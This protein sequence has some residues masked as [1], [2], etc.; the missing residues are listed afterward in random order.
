MPK[1]RKHKN[2][3]QD[4]MHTIDIQE[5]IDY[6]K[7]PMY[8]FFKYKSN[9]KT[10]Y[11]STVEK[12]DKDMHR[13]IYFSFSRLQEGMPIRIE[14]VKA[15]WGRAWIKDKR[16]SDIIF[17]DTL[18]NKDTY[19][20]RRKKGINSLLNFQK[21]FSTNP[22]FPVIINKRYEINITKNLK[23]TGNFELVRE[24][25]DEF[26]K[27][28]IE[29]AVF[30]TDEHTNNKIN[31]ENDLNLIASSIAIE[32]YIENTKFKY[33]LYHIDKH[34]FFYLDNIE[35]HKNIFKQSVINIY[36]AIFNNIFYICPNE[37]C[38]SCTY[39]ELCSKVENIN[40]IVDKE[41]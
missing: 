21:N 37:R 28:Y 38:I 14:D 29:I 1:E 33:M 15:A 25:R 24:M 34:N 3:L 6:A 2:L 10:E 11:I 41:V 27:T 32:E 17:S 20:E 35:M 40:K 9:E 4:S 8:Y 7:C 5:V 30:K 16:R 39:K 31:K 22:G 19:N 36:K 18:S 23:L 26:D 12:Y 13:V